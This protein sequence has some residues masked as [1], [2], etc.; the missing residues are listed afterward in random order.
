MLEPQYGVG[1]VLVLMLIWSLM[2]TRRTIQ[3]HLR[4]GSTGAELLSALYKVL[5]GVTWLTGNANPNSSLFNLIGETRI[6]VYVIVIIGLV[7]LFAW[8]HRAE[9]PW[10]AIRRACSVV[11]VGMWVSIIYDLVDR[12]ASATVTLLV[13]FLLMLMYGVVRQSYTVLVES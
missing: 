7:H 10:I 11:G 3:L 6:G 8:G 13:P 2:R 4:E 12:G 5:L 9:M 1:L